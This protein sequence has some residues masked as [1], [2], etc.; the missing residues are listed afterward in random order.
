M[1]VFGSAVFCEFVM[2]S[3][4]F[5]AASWLPGVD[6]CLVMPGVYG[7]DPRE[8]PPGAAE[9]EMEDEDV[10]G[11]GEDTDDEVPNGNV[12]LV[13]EEVDYLARL[14]PEATAYSVLGVLEAITT[15]LGD[16]W[17]DGHDVLVSSLA[18][19]F[20]QLNDDRETVAQSMMIG[21]LR[22]CM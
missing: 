12:A 11:A 19:H 22:R 4:Q 18:W 13:G 17:E 21:A 10:V 1:M 15:T 6:R 9:W 3:L 2:I 14:N 20:Y 5:A 8:F 7:L 16:L